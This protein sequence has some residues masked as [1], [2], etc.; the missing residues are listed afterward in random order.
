MKMR[1][2]VLEPDRL[3]NPTRVGRAYSRVVPTPHQSRRI[4]AF[5]LFRTQRRRKTVDRQGISDFPTDHRQNM[6]G[7]TRDRSG[8]SGFMALRNGGRA[9]ALSSVSWLKFRAKVFGIVLSSHQKPPCPKSVENVRNCGKLFPRST[10]FLGAPTLRSCT[11]T[12]RGSNSA[13]AIFLS[14]TNVLSTHRER[15]PGL[16]QA[17]SINQ[18]ANANE[19]ARPPD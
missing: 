3:K 18:I 7:K 17:A 2:A 12:A 15:G 4:P 14:G 8:D 16:C 6:T 13:A 11:T 19:A 1:N 5:R 10:C 9:Q